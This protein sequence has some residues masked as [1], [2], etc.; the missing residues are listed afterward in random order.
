ATCRRS[1]SSATCCWPRN[2]PRNSSPWNR[3]RRLL[4]TFARTPPAPSPAPTF[5]SMAAGPRSEFMNQI[6]KWVKGSRE[7]HASG[8]GKKRINLALQGGGAHGAFTWG[9]LDQ[10]LEDGRLIVDGISGAS[11]GALNGLVLADGL[12]RG[13]PEEAR[14]RLA[15]FWRAASF[16]GSLPNVQRQVVEHMFSVVPLSDSPM[17]A[18]LD[19][20]GRFMSPYELNPLN[21]NPLREVIEKFVDFEAV[22]ATGRD[23]FISATNVQSGKLR[24]FTRDEVT[25]EVAMASACLP[26]LF[27]AVEIDGVP[28]WDGGY[29]GNPALFTFLRATETE[30]VLMVQIYPLKRL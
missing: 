30:D 7:H 11:A 8:S 28:Y 20:M 12:A 10:L 19:A 13:G 3:S 6:L 24:V 29:T 5:P 4:S 18:W 17:K 21:L 27:Q 15:E 9:V 2:P 1:R 22:R 25:C 23:I 26:F 14:K 16:G